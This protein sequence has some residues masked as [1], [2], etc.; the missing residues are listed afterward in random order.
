MVL[1]NSGR[2]GSRRFTEESPV[3]DIGTGDLLFGD[4]MLDLNAETDMPSERELLRF[5]MYLDGGMDWF[6]CFQPWTFIWFVVISGW[7]EHKKMNI[8]F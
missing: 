3:S 4:L 1:R 6:S 5:N 2:V 8:L 7:N